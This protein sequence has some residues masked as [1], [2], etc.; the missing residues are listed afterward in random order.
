MKDLENW[1]TFVFNNSGGVF[2][3]PLL[4][5]NQNS[6]KLLKFNYFKNFEF[7]TNLII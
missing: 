4:T 6:L 1:Y 7:I 3:P 5:K 2:T